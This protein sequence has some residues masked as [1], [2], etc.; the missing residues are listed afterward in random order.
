MSLIAA[1]LGLALVL[2]ILWDAFETVLLPR[3]VTGAFRRPA[4]A[5]AGSLQSA[6]SSSQFGL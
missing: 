5:D 3:R 1:A 6:V 2:V 4:Y